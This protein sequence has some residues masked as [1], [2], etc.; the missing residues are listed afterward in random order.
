[1]KALIHI[2]I[3]LLGA[4]SLSA[5][6]MDS[7]GRE[8]GKSMLLLGGTAHIGNGE[9]IEQAAIGV[10]DGKFTV[11]ADSRLI[12]INRAEYDEIIEIPDQHV[13]PGF[14]AQG[15]NMG[16][17]EI[18]AVR[19][20]QDDWEVGAYKPHVRS[21]I[22]FNTD[23][24]VIPT[25]VSNG[26]LMAQVTPMGGW[27]QGTS[28][29][30]HLDGWN[31]EDALIKEDDAIHVNWPR[32]M[33]RN[34]WWPT[35]GPIEKNKNYEEQ[36]RE[37]HNFFSE[38]QAYGSVESHDTE[39][40]RFEAMRGVFPKDGAAPAQ[41]VFITCEGAKDITEAIRFGKEFGLDLVIVGA[42]DAWMV[43]DILVE[44]EVPVILNQV[45]RLPARDHSAYDQPYRTPSALQKAGVKFGITIN[46]WDAFW[47]YRTLPY[48]AGQAVAFG[49]DRE[50]AVAS[51]TGN[52][53]EILG[54]GESTGTLTAEKDA[55]FFISSGDMLDVM[56]SNPTRAWIQ[57]REVNL[58]DKQKA[59]Y[60]KFKEKY[61]Q[62]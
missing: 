39:N 42:R 46:S 35:P 40:R 4:I 23:S 3:L 53:A 26:I 49:L 48:Q 9:V 56:T 60:R 12:R 51:I 57:G 55:T 13:Y 7:P 47:N 32:L 54:I 43:T 30:M 52:L 21:A 1:M 38:A 14:I 37:L 20:T 27:I 17:R 34:V 36:Y 62:E 11:V 2:T 44:N 22:A 25:N 50:D 28:S 6:S 15:T 41:K 10:K 5:Q 45:N 31:W 33:T 24:R 19:A 59:L 8:S 61:E 18:G 29:V 58:D 16:L